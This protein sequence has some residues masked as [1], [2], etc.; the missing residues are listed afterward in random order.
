MEKEK[1][2]PLSYREAEHKK[3]MRIMKIALV[4]QLVALWFSIIA[5]VIRILR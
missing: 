1:K 5:L 2:A 3:T 4:M